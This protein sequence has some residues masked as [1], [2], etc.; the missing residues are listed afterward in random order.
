MD[1][2]ISV[3]LPT[4]N[5][6]IQTERAVN[7]IATSCPEIVEIIVIDDCGSAPYVHSLNNNKYGIG[8][9][10]VRLNEN[11]GAGMARQEGVNISSGIYIA[12]LDS[13]EIYTEKWLDAVINIIQTQLLDINIKTVISGVAVG[14]Q[15]SARFVRKYLQFMPRGSRLLQT[16][17]MTIMLNPFYTSTLV[18]NRD[19]CKFK[20][21]LRYCEDYYTSMHAVF[22]ADKIIMLSTKSCVLGRKPKSEGGLSSSGYHMY[23]GELLVRLDT[24]KDRNIPAVYRIILPVGIIYQV[25]RILIKIILFRH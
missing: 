21:G 4:Y 2:L 10:V 19:I 23:L 25:I 16:R 22:N 20:S 13:D 12:F 15:L 3:I 9:K 24:I 17:L 7:S 6:T 1:K 8:V 18:V 14:E 11:V 5:R